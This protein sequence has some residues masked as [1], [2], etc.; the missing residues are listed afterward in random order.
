M[1]IAMCGYCSYICQ[2][3]DIQGRWRDVENHEKTCPERLMMVIGQVKDRLE[4]RPNLKDGLDFA[5][6]LD[7]FLHGTYSLNT[8]LRF[9]SDKRSELLKT[10]QPRFLIANMKKAVICMRKLGIHEP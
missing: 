8:A 6:I 4:S 1:P 7:K 2:G 5:Y 10:K 9:A 3:E